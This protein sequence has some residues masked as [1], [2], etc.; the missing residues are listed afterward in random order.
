MAKM[1]VP[2][3][4]LLWSPTE[5]LIDTA[6]VTAYR[7]WLAE[8]QIVSCEDYE[9]LWQWSVTDNTGFW[10][11]LWRYFDIQSNTA[12]HRVTTS[13][14]MAPGTQWF[15]GSMVNFA[16]HI[17][18]HERPDATALFSLSETRVLE[19]LSWSDFASQVR[20]LATAMRNRGVQQGDT[21]G[22]LMP[23][24]PETVVAML[25]SISIGAVWSNAAP[26]FGEKTILDRFIQIKPTWLFVADGYQYGGKAYD[27]SDVIA[28]IAAALSDSLE[29]VVYFSYLYPNKAPTLPAI[30]WQDLLDEPD[31]GRAAFHFT[32]V[33]H[34]HPLWILFSSGTTGMPKAIVHSHVGAL[35]EM[36]KF[37]TFHM[38]L[39]P[40]HISFFYTTTGWV[41]F[42]IQVAFMLTGAAG[43]LYDGSPVYPTPDVLWKMAAD[44]QAHYFGASPSYVQLM[45]QQDIQP[46]QRFDLTALKSVLCSGSPATPDTFAWFY[47]HVKKDLW[48][49]SQS[50]GTEIVSAFVG[51]SPTLP[52]YAGEIQTR[53]LGM[54]VAAWDE[55]GMPVIDQVGELVCKTPFPSM[56]LHFLHDP[57]NQRY[58]D[59]Y[60]NYFPNVW[61]HGDFIK[62]N[63]RG[64]VYIYGRS[65]ATLNRY[66]VR[67][68]TAEIYGVLEALPEVQDSLVVCIE[69]P[70]GDFFMP[71]F[72]QL[73]P[74][75][76]LTEDVKKTLAQHLRTQCSPRHVPD[77]FF[78]IAAV[79]YTL[80]GKKL[81]I[82]VRKILMGQ[83]ID[84]A[85]SIDTT[86]NPE[87]LAYFVD[88]ATHHLVRE[89]LS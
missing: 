50:G 89:V 29:Q 78:S 73:S 47:R 70:R 28:H 54:D 9:A 66:G 38:D 75:V 67:I 5:D 86:K 62:I 32:R 39:K 20:T 41:M 63:G 24:I 46:N 80:T 53:I 77:D 33:P 2:E 64:G 12:Y 55:Q 83:T 17:L 45:Q 19:A 48:L 49:T 8:E 31:P 57:N 3:G 35:L 36:M 22:C 21:I 60:F 51:G 10:S 74:G 79:P 1:A 58:Q 18:R 40:E 26:E 4:A 6:N 68:G 84:T 37:V 59:A 13:Q 61:R 27:R 85:V 76:T 52:V 25:A 69:G 56:P 87:A 16:E 71:I 42:N 34:D 15:P 81:E 14:L 65:D 72:V 88:F 30:R 82:P 23:N 43:V 44:T 11:S 7:H